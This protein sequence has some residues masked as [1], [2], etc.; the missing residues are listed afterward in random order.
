MLKIFKL[1]NCGE[2]ENTMCDIRDQQTFSDLKGN[3][4]SK[5]PW[6]H[7]MLPQLAFVCALFV[8]RVVP[9]LA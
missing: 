5:S 1:S 8:V 2:A 3:D 7:G 6:F 9:P 4:V